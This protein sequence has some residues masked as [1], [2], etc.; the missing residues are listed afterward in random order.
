MTTI[1]L[2]T[3]EA[4]SRRK[5]LQAILIGSLLLAIVFA[6]AARYS[7]E[8]HPTPRP[9]P[10]TIGTKKISTER[11]G[12]LGSRA[13]GASIHYIPMDGDAETYASDFGYHG[14][15]GYNGSL[16]HNSTTG[17]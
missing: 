3:A 17:E 1:K 8:H 10:D 15:A 5:T 4:A 9:V 12:Q 7:R 14:R 2:E 13:V 11:D 16:S 6:V